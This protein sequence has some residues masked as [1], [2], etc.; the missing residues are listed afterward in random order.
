[1]AIVSHKHRVV[2]FPMAKNCSTSAKHLFYLLDVGMPFRTAKKKYGLWGHVHKYYPTQTKE[3]WQQIFDAYESIVI[4]RDPIKRFLSAYGNRIVHM[5]V[6]ETVGGASARILAAGH[7][8]QPSLEEFV[9]NLEFYCSVSS[10]MK[11]HIAPQEKIVGDIFPKI[12][13][14]YDTSQVPEFEAFMSERCGSQIVL[15]REQSGGPKFTVS[16]LSERSLG[17]LLDFY[18]KDYKML[19]RFYSPPSL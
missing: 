16:D 4:V 2:F 15:P 11:N 12:K 13:R 7:P 1:M 9:Q 19:S 17:K 3:E 18:R 8:L 6:L 5:K 14:V 10:Y